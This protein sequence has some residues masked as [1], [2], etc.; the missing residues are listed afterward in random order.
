MTIFIKF[1][2]KPHVFYWLGDSLRVCFVWMFRSSSQFCWKT[3]QESPLP[4]CWLRNGSGLWRH[5]IVEF[6]YSLW[7]FRVPLCSRSFALAVRFLLWPPPF[8]STR[9]SQLRR[10]WSHNPKSSTYWDLCSE[11]LCSAIESRPYWRSLETTTVGTA[12][13]IYYADFHRPPLSQ[14]ATQLSNL[15]TL[16]SLTIKNIVLISSSSRSM[17]VT[18][19]G[20]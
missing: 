1:L 5:A 4:I 7:H 11:Q 19:S 9:S 13:R 6:V 12:H 15:Q 17:G 3:P 10:W 2:L 20:T 14:K 8:R 18:S 16:P